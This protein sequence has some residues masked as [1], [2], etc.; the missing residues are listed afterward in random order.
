MS[1]ISQ[2][3]LHEQ[4]YFLQREY[5]QVQAHYSLSQLQHMYEQ[6]YRMIQALDRCIEELEEQ[7]LETDGEYWND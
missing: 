6:T 5:R 3:L 1:S 4:M 7:E 2:E